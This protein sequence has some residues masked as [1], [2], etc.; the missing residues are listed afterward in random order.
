MRGWELDAGVSEVDAGVDV[1]DPGRGVNWDV[2][3]WN[4]ELRVMLAHVLRGLST[5][6]CSYAVLGVWAL[7]KVAGVTQASSN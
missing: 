7:I 2:C 3:G 4:T 6:Q 5:H 1:G